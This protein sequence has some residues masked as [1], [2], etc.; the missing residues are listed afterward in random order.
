MM[1]ATISIIIILS[2][3]GWLFSLKLKIKNLY[4]AILNGFSVYIVLFLYDIVSWN[5]TCQAFVSGIYEPCSLTAHLFSFIGVGGF[6]LFS[7]LIFLVIAIFTLLLNTIY[8]KLKKHK[9]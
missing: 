7:I 6:V 2:V 5:G 4:A 1:I 8:H 9:I 3:I